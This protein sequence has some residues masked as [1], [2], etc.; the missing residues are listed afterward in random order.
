[1]YKQQRGYSN[2]CFCYKISKLKHLDRGGVQVKPQENTNSF[3][4]SSI[5]IPQ[6]K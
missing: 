5:F 3:T 4:L 6:D 1:M 2:S